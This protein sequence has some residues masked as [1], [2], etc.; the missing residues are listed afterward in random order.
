ME[1]DGRVVR[2]HTD[3]FPLDI[4]DAR[5]DRL[6]PEGGRAVIRVL[7]LESI[8]WRNRVY[9]FAARRA[10]QGGWFLC[11]EG[12]GE[13]PPGGLAKLFTCKLSSNGAA[14]RKK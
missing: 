4:W 1:M 2:L 10:A 8:I 9:R 7:R 5:R 6:N 11:A 13:D 3:T 12:S 14:F